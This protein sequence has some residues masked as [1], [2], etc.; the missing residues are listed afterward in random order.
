MVQE[1]LPFPAVVFI[2]H[3][4]YRIVGNETVICKSNGSWSH[5]PSCQQISCQV[6]QHSAPVLLRYSNGT[7]VGSLRRYQCRD[8]YIL[9][10]SNEIQCNSDGLWSGYIPSC[11][12]IP[13]NEFPFVANAVQISE[14]I[15][16]GDSFQLVCAEGYYVEGANSLTCEPDGSWGDYLPICAPVI[17]GTTPIV[18]HSE[19]VSRNFVFGETFTYVCDKGYTMI[20]EGTLTCTA[21]GSWY[22]SP[23]LP[24]SVM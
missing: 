15:F 14:S 2:C 11:D 9:R 3:E 20:G 16:F 1:D 7:I 8:G 6:P 18:P 13:C 10:G 23:H 17:C 4:G 5:I 12:P 21:N 24:R 19:Q 22:P